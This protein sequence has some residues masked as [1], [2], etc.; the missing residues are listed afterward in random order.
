MMLGRLMNAG[1]LSQA[2]QLAAIFE[3][4][5]PDL[6]IV[7]VRCT[8]K[9]NWGEGGDLQSSHTVVH[10]LKA[11]I[12]KPNPHNSP[13]Q[14][15]SAI[16]Y[17]LLCAQLLLHIYLMDSL[18]EKLRYA[19]SRPLTIEYYRVRT[20]GLMPS[21]TQFPAT[22]QDLLPSYPPHVRTVCHHHE[23]CTQQG[24]L[25]QIAVH[26]SSGVRLGKGGSMFNVGLL[27][28][29]PSYYTSQYNIQCISVVS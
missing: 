27:Y 8:L 18:A 26:I 24:K 22:S 28:C 25:L 3:H 13:T 9:K 21:S 19:Q 23:T 12:S 16:C 1:L 15:L 20:Q 5:S 14:I 4:N 6:T 10:V 2:R 11:I 29:P 17:F 7:L